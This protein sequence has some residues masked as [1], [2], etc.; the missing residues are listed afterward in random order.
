[1]TDRAAIIQRALELEHQHKDD[2][3]WLGFEWSDIKAH[4]RDLNNLVVDGLLEIA[5]RSRTCTHYR[6]SKDNARILEELGIVPES[7]RE[8]PPDLFSVIE[9]CDDAK[10][11]VTLALCAPRPV[12]VL[13][14][15]PYATAKTMFLS[16]LARLPDARYA[17]GGTSTRAGVIDYVLQSRPR[18]LIIDELDKMDMRDFSALL[19]LMETGT[20][21]RLKHKATELEHLV[22]WVFAGANNMHRIP[23]ELKSRFLKIEMHEYT[24]AEYQDVVRA[25]L[26]KREKIDPEIASYIS[27]VLTGKTKDVRDA[28][29]I[30]RMASSIQ[31]VDSLVRS[32]FK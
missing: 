17:L 5:Y 8:I 25:V 13:L 9:G 28:V 14:H 15:G 3:G 19:S 24:D 30:A 27:R 22:C 21:A 10:R 23:G 12:H 11:L 6:L 2:D 1:M 31:E 16:E 4:A 29:R 26:I 7:E 32:I 18:Y 20:L